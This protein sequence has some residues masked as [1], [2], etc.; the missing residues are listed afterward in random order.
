MTR[1][2]NIGFYSLSDDRA[3][4]ASGSSSMQRCEVLITDRCNFSCPY[5]RGAYGSSKGHADTDQ[6]IEV[7][8]LWAEDGLVNVRFSGGEPTMHPDLV[9]MVEFAQ[10]SGVRRIA[11]STNGS[12]RRDVYD[13]L[14]EA[15]VND[16]SVS[17]D[18]CCASGAE[19]MAGRTGVFDRVVGNIRYLADRTYVTVGVVLNGANVGDGAE[20]V[21]FAHDLGVADIRVISSAQYNRLLEGVAA[22]GDDVLDAHPILRYRV[23]NIRRGRNVRGLSDGD[24]RTCWLAMDDS[25]V[26]GDSHYACVIH[27]REGGKAVGKVGP[28]MRAERLAWM[29]SH[30]P[31]EDAICRANCLDVCVAHNNRVEA[32]RGAQAGNRHAVCQIQAREAVL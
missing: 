17:L 5:C 26:V 12:L 1:L 9:E 22:I 4:T 14:L 3:R 29:E 19:S 11:V 16:F 6:V 15:G 24:S 20:I 27:M 2:D 32:L 13:R 25:V 7:L 23:D 18:A 28:N 8:D 21:R 30:D 10:A 31:H